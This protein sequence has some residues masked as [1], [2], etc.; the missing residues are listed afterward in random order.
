MAVFDLEAI[1][2]LNTQPYEESLK[3][4]G[5][6]AKSFDGGGGLTKAAMVGGA[7]LAATGAALVGFGKT[8]VDTGKEFD[9]SMSQ[10]A[11]TLGYTTDDIKN[12]TNGAGKNF[13][14]LRKKALQ[15][16]SET[17]FSAS[18]AAEG[19][20]ILAM[21]GYDAEESMDMIEDVLHLA[22]AGSMDMAS[23]AQYVS[24][25]MKGFADETKDSGYYANLMAKGATLANTS[26]SQLGEAMS[27]GSATA[28]AYNQ[29]A[30][31]MTIALLRL[32]E[33]G[34]AGSA[35]GTALSA[36]MK[37]LYTPTDQAKKALND[38]G[39]EVYNENGEAR[40]FNDVVNDLTTAMEGMTDEEANAYKQSIFGI[41]G[42][43]AYNKMAVTSTKTQGKWAKALSSA[44]EGAGE[45]AKQYNTMT[46]NLQGDVDIWK[47][48]VDGFKIAVS[49][50]LMPSIRDFV[51]FGSDSVGKFTKAF[52]EGGL[53]GLATE[54]GNALSELIK[55]IGEKLPSFVSAGANLLTSL[56]NGIIEALP[57]IASTATDV[58]VSLAEHIGENLPKLIPKAAE[59]IVTIAQGLADNAD[60]LIDAAAKA[61]KGLID[62]LSKAMP[63]IIKALPKI[64]KT[65]A[66]AVG[67]NLGTIIQT[68]APALIAK[69]AGTAVFNGLKSGIG[70]IKD[71]VVSFM[72][73]PAGPI[74]A[75]SGAIFGL[76]VAI[77]NAMDEAYETAYNSA[78]ELT[79]SEQTLADAINDEK[80]RWADVKTAR[81]DAAANVEIE[82]GKYK[83][84]WQ[85]LEKIVDK[86]GK[87]KKGY[88][89]QAKLI[90]GELSDALDIEIGYIGDQIDGYENLRDAID[91]AI[92]RKEAELI[93]AANE[94]DYIDAIK[95]KKDA[96][97]KLASAEKALADQEKKVE[98]AAAK[99]AEVQ[100]K[101]NKLDEDGMR[102]TYDYQASYQA[103]E[104]ELSNAQGEL[105]GAKEKL[106]DLTETY[107]TAK[108][109]LQNYNTTISNFDALQSAVASGGIEELRDALFNLNNSFITAESGTAESLGKQT[110]EY[111][112][113]YSEMLGIV[114]ETGSEAAKQAAEESKA[115]VEKSIK[116]LMKLDPQAAKQ[117]KLMLATTKSY[118]KDFKTAGGNLA[119]GI[120]DGLK[121]KSY[122][123]DN[124]ARNVMTNSL[125][126]AKKI[127]RISSPSRVWRDEIGKMLG[128]GLA[129]GLEDSEGLVQSAA[130]NLLTAAEP[131]YGY[132]TEYEM[133]GA[134][135]EGGYG[136][137]QITINVYG[138]EGQD[139]GALADEISIR[140]QKMYR[141]EVAKYA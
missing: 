106:D 97:V 65:L 135:G 54:V 35:A 67:D 129:V 77:A 81:K 40:D 33:Q 80:D 53:P 124:A 46:D 121:G 70:G 50:N 69:K 49:D 58:V 72:K 11:A 6:D 140:L 76:G 119:Q 9:S 132:D 86:N 101:I 73:G 111:Q 74:V 20:N 2:R 42:L 141:R 48:A 38:L 71:K 18:Q 32:A 14:A 64:L 66:K 59:A 130:E 108:D 134:T 107:E 90:T 95:G 61:F 8:S 29:D 15:M 19:L 30:E 103:L 137:G 117:F 39:V 110:E 102:G 79:T 94:Q 131:D 100:K 12:D 82:V 105:D 13:E 115:L 17:N 51:K 26:V 47:S 85:Q 128:E 133:S 75:I 10:I 63:I 57:G 1:L 25:S 43:R 56:L 62:G 87:V 126:A 52:T 113:A 116:E 112:K 138:A 89:D 23:A 60:K 68:V 84:L 21:S 5:N 24:G 120:A 55:K 31:S 123:I 3:Q 114:K 44:S 125:I 34:E 93:L 139:V 88:E 4:A 118:Y 127:S 36:A 96:A 41:Q 91:K 78:K 83:S 98:D 45:A 22:A 122:I 104:T 7:A 99:V 109:N 136:A 16:G 27:S 92:E 28:A 37:D